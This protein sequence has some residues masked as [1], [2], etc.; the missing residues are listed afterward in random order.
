MS[1]PITVRLDRRREERGR[2]GSWRDDSIRRPV[3]TRLSRVV[4]ALARDL[5]VDS[6][7]SA[8]SVVDGVPVTRD[9]CHGTGRGQGRFLKS[10]VHS[11][12]LGQ[13][14][15]KPAHLLRKL[16]QLLGDD[17]VVI[18]SDNDPAAVNGSSTSGR[19]RHPR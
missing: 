1:D 11:L 6:V 2:V 19:G 14:L 15:L 9:L 18:H 12:D 10:G 16:A 3:T 7:R 13:T 4:I 17:L 8:H 5:F